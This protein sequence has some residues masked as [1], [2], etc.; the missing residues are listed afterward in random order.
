[1]KRKILGGKE[2]VCDICGSSMEFVFVDGFGVISQCKC[3]NTVKGKM[4]DEVNI[5]TY[6]PIKS[7]GKCRIK[8]NKFKELRK[9]LVLECGRGKNFQ[10]KFISDGIVNVYRKNV[11]CYLT[12]Q[13]L[14]DYFE[15]C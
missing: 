14:E 3:G 15:I 8:P 7:E 9:H 6:D 1:M 11:S 12:K 5:Y 10:Y 2:K 13:Q 4:T